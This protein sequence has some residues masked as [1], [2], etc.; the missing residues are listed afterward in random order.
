MGVW[1][2]CN[3][4]FPRPEEPNGLDDDCDGSID[5]DF[6]CMPGETETQQCGYSDV[7][8]CEMGYQIRECTSTGF[9]SSWGSC[10]GAVYPSREVMNGIDDD[11]DGEIDEGLYD[12]GNGVYFSKVEVYPI[13]GGRITPGSTVVVKPHLT[14][15]SASTYNDVEAVAYLYGAGSRSIKTKFDIRKN[16]DNSVTLLLDIPYWIEPGHYWIQ[17]SVYHENFRKVK[18]VP[19]KVE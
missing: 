4:I 11:C 2:G 17:V 13:V 12:F 9:W 15:K 5:E 6:D 8:A 16:K 14:S 18:F 1:T 3:A 19:V 10:I 7:G